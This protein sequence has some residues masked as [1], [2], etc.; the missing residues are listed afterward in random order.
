MSETRKPI[1]VIAEMAYSHEGDPARARTIIDAA[2][3]SETNAVQ[4]QI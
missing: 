3:D 4:F 2:T 1:Y